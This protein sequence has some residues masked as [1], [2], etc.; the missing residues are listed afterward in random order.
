MD[1]PNVKHNLTRKTLSSTSIKILTLFGLKINTIKPD[2][3]QRIEH[4]N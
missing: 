2:S 4:G 3:D 1:N